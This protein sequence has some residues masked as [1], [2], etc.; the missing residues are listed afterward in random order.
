MTGTLSDAERI[1][2]AGVVGAGGAGFPTHIKARGAAEVVIGNG[3]E[4]E[5]LLAKDKA[6]MRAYPDQVVAGMAVM[7]GCV[8]AKR[9]IVGIKRKNTREIEAMRTAARRSGMDIS[10]IELSDFYPAGD[11]HVLVY[12]ATGRVVPAGGIPLAAGAVVS[13]VETLLNVSRAVSGHPVTHKFVTVTGE[14]ERPATFKAPVGASFARLIEAAGG[15]TAR[16]RGG[17]EVVQDGPMMGKI[18]PPGADL[19][20]VIVTKTTSGVIVLPSGHSLLSEKRRSIEHQV[21]LARSACISCSQCTDHCPR[22]LLGHPLEPHLIMRAFG[23][24]NPDL[25]EDLSKYPELTMAGLC[26]G[27][28]VCSLVCPMGLSPR[29]INERVKA[30]MAEA[31]VKWAPKRGPKPPHPARAGRQI[32]SRRIVSRLG[33]SRYAH[34]QHSGSGP[35]TEATREE[36]IEL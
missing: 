18:I 13:N 6:I 21:R 27:C 9:G 35:A 1:E 19:E 29:C 10:V 25:S 4:C 17:F 2:A 30:A 33:L 26:T 22:Y 15:V 28:G 24:R 20:K 34:G 23:Y 5:P 3:V 12:E 36:L 14:V 32:P 7:M 31:R 11:E 8:G 16:V